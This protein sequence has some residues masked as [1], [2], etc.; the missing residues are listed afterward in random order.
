MTSLA[1]R[2][3]EIMGEDVAH[4]DPRWVTA[5]RAAS[6][7]GVSESAARRILERT[8]DKK[9]ACVVNPDGRRIRATVY[10]VVRVEPCGS[11][12]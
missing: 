9:T 2:L 12:G 6:I 10:D 5:A 8:C 1:E 4:D 11:D 3:R 7:T